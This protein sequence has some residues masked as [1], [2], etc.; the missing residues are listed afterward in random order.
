MLGFGD[1]ESGSREYPADL[2]HVNINYVKQEDCKRAYP[3]ENIRDNML[4]AADSGQI[5]VKTLAKEIV[6]DLSMTAITKPWSVLYL[7]VIIVQMIN[8]QEC[9]RE[10][11]TR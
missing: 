9:T 8:S 5:P 7:G 2:M 10:F 1:L 11:Q 4:C 6:A 3:G